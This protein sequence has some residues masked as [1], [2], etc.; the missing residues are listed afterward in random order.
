M[1]PLVLAC[2]HA[3]EV[4]E[5]IHQY[6]NAQVKA[7]VHQL[8]VELKSTKK[9]NKSITELVLRIKAI[10]NSLL[11]VGDLITKQD[12]IG[13]I[14]NGLPEEHNPF[15]MHMYGCPIT[16]TLCE[17]EALLYLQEAQLDK[18]HQELVTSS[19][20]ANVAHTNQGNG[21]SKGVYTR[22]RGRGNHFTH[23]QGRGRVTNS[24][25]N[26]PTC[27][28][29]GNYGHSVMSCWHIFD[30]NFEPPTTNNN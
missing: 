8:R 25:C 21:G 3:Y 5:K 11:A 28:L 16:H 17:V 2:K 9:G 14:L 23:G 26:R 22:S 27:Q 30:E 19:V 1:L 20:A 7:R 6:F 12:Q 24:T 18:F 13:S 4:W 29:Y 10:A 15:V